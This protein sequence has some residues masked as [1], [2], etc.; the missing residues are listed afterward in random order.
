MH[1]DDNKRIVQAE[2]AMENV[3]ESI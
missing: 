3:K 1:E 2:K